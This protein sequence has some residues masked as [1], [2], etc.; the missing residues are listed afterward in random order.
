MVRLWEVSFSWAGILSNNKPIPHPLTDIIYG[1][2]IQ[3]AKDEK[4]RKTELIF[5]P[6]EFERQD[7]SLPSLQGELTSNAEKEGRRRSLG[8]VVHVQN[9]PSPSSN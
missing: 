3:R 9:L 8:E 6:K 1:H 7:S 2:N 5:A 4:E